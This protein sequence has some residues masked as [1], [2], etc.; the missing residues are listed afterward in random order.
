MSS[1]TSSLWSDASLS[2]AGARL[3][4]AVSCEVCV[5]GAGIAG[6]TT[7]Y[8]LAREG[9]AAVVLDAQPAIAPGETEYTTAHLASAI[10]DRFARLIA[11]RGEDVARRAYHSHAAAIDRIEQACRDEAIDCD[12]ARLDGYLFPGASRADDV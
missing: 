6:L 2:R 4:G 11:V 9:R 8:L 5:V 1:T 10:D 12:F 3:D 7:A